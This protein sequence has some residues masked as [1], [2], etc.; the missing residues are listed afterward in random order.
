MNRAVGDDSLVVFPAQGRPGHVTR[1]TLLEGERDLEAMR[2]ALEALGEA[3]CALADAGASLVD[4]TRLRGGGL[5]PVP[6]LGV[7]R[8]HVLS[9]SDAA[10]A[11][12]YLDLDVFRP[13]WSQVEVR[14]GLTLYFRAFYAVAN[15]DF[16]AVTLPHQLRLA[17]AARPGTVRYFAPSLTVEEEAFLQESPPPPDRGR[18]PRCHAHV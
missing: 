8:A 3:A 1:I 12:A 2:G 13:A 6:P 9:A 5:S 16:L 17:R 15:V 4:V 7:N 14:G 10:L 18:L 11:T